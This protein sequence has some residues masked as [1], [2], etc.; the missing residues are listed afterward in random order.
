MACLSDLICF[1]KTS[2]DF[3]EKTS[4]KYKYFIGMITFLTNDENI[5]VFMGRYIIICAI[6]LLIW[7]IKVLTFLSNTTFSNL[8]L[9]MSSIQ[10]VVGNT[11]L[12]I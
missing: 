5:W 4:A 7:N 12:V 2:A 3:F 11:F 10:Q 6:K 8:F 1:D 9:S